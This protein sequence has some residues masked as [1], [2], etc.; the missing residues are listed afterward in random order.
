MS[1]RK[2]GEGFLRDSR[3]PEMGE[4]SKTETDGGEVG[5]NDDD[6]GDGTR[7]ELRRNPRRG[8]KVRNFV[9]RSSGR[10][11]ES[12][13]SRTLELQDSRSGNEFQFALNVCAL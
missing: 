6:G 5:G 12:W 1:E 8:F 7:M 10:S 13:S 2:S 4:R 11:E 3:C 9:G